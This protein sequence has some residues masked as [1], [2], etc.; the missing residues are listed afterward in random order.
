MEVRATM[1]GI[2][3]WVNRRMTGSDVEVASELAKGH[4]GARRAKTGE[5]LARED[6]G[7]YV[8]PMP[9]TAGDSVTVRYS[10]LLAQSGAEQVYLHMGF[11]RERWNR[12][13]DVPMGKA[14]PR[15]FEARVNLPLEETSRFHFCF[16]DNAGH[17]DNNSGRDWSCEIH[18]GEITGLA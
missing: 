6:D 16:R 15:T 8:S 12:V 3:D 4:P 10:G 5:A 14:G 13:S 18:H 11:G 17:W 9:I 1:G 2:I 7:V